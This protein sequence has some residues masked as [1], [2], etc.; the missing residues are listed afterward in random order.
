MQADL[1][2][3]PHDARATLFDALARRL[4]GEARGTSIVRHGVTLLALCDA[5]TAP[6]APWIAGLAYDAHGL[7]D[8]SLRAA[9]VAGKGTTNA[10]EAL[11]EGRAA[12]DDWCT[13]A[14][15]TLTR[16]LRPAPSYGFPLVSTVRTRDAARALAMAACGEVDVAAIDVPT[17]ATVDS[18]R[19]EVIALGR[20]LPGRVWTGEAELRPVVESLFTDRA[21]AWARK[22]LRWAGLVDL[23]PSTRERARLEARRASPPE[24]RP[25]RSRRPHAS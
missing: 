15:C 11:R 16:A 21:L 3:A 19:V 9:I 1:A 13:V 6:E 7:H 2:T 12:V 5:T 22:A 25:F 23:R 24:V 17:L 10:V 14:H 20:S 18:S 8:G 4:D